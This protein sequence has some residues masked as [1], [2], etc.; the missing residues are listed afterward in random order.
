[1]LDIGNI[2]IDGDDNIVDIEGDDNDGSDGKTDNV[3]SNYIE[4]ITGES[5]VE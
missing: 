2:F 1:M 3:G 5:C 4:R